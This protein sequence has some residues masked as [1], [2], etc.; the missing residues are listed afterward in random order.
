[1]IIKQRFNKTKKN[2]IG[3]KSQEIEHKRHL[4]S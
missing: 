1:M 4:Q 2:Y 3:E